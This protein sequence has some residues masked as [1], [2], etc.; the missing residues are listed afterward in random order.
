MGESFTIQI[1]SNLVSQLTNTG[2]KSKKKTRKPKP[3]TPTKVPKK[4]TVDSFE[5]HKGSSADAGWT[6][7]APISPPPALFLPITPQE[8]P[9]QVSNQELDAIRSTLKESEKVVERLQKQEENML[10]EV[11]KKAKDLHDKEFK[12]PYQNPFLCLIEKEA[13]L[14]CYKENPKNPLICGEVVTRFKNCV[15]ISAQQVSSAQ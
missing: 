3:K 1:S 11:T 8:V 9:P 12:L 5:P 6:L 7:P 10:Q 15:R 13:C 14:E 4:Q 2:D